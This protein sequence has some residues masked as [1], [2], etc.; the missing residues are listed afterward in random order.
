LGG[1]VTIEHEHHEREPGL[2]LKRAIAHTGASP[3]CLNQRLNAQSVVIDA[4]HT[5]L[6]DTSPNEIFFRAAA[7]YVSRTSGTGKTVPQNHAVSLLAKDLFAA[8]I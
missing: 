5:L 7:Y 3:T 6:V 1:V 8:R 4:E 2:T